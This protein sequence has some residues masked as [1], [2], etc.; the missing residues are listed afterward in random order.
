[1]ALG[2]EQC[3]LTI[4]VFDEPER[5][6][7]TIQTLLGAGLPVEQ[8]CLAALA[9]TMACVADASPISEADCSLLTTLTQKVEAWPGGQNGHSIVATSGSLFKTLSHAQSAG[10][11][12]R[13]HARISALHWSEL[14]EQIRNG[15]IVLIVSASSPAQQRLSTRTLLN[16][17]SRSVQTYEFAISGSAEPSSNR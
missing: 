10:D 4:A 9:T 7:R 2:A 17:S 12:A 11:G 14:V 3:R 1:M 5:L 13:T 8:F 15:A 16:E 6:W